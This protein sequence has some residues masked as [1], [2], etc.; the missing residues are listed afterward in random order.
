MIW[1]RKEQCQSLHYVR[2]DYTTNAACFI[3]PQKEV[4]K[5][6]GALENEDE[7]FEG[8]NIISGYACLTLM[9]YV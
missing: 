2:T 8:W 5:V 1:Q 3:F 6:Y 7:T 4:R 9:K